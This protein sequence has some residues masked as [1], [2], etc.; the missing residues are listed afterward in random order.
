MPS[1]QH[2][3]DIK[4]EDPPTTRS[5]DSKPINA[6]WARRFGTLAA[7]T[8]LKRVRPRKGSIL[9]LSPRLCVKY[10]DRVDLSEASA[11]HFIA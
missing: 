2:P 11:M 10:G 5:T 1:R 3:T 9:V 8:L 4:T 6:T 7:V